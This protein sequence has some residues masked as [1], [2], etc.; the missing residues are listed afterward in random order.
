MSRHRCVRD[1]QGKG[2]PLDLDAKFHTMKR[3]G[4]CF[5]CSTEVLKGSEVYRINLLVGKQ[6]RIHFCNTC[7][8]KIM[9]G[10]IGGF[11]ERSS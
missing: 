9:T 3:D 5:G 11:Y 6:E 10:I 4:Y 2:K 1:I 8:L 7:Q